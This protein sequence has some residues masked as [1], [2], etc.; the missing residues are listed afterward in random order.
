MTRRLAFAFCLVAGMAFGHTAESAGAAPSDLDPAIVGVLQKDGIRVKDGAKVVMEFWFVSA[1]PGGSASGAPN[2][3]MPELPHGALMGVVRF[4]A[5]YMD[6]RGQSIQPGVYSMRFSFYPENGDHQGA[7]PQRDFLVLSPIANDKDP[8][9]TPAFDALM[10]MSR[11]ASGTPHPLVLSMWKQDAA[12]FKPGV[13][14]EGESDQALQLKV[15]ETPI[16]VIVAGVSN[17]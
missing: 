1:L 17:H 11:K 9:A 14:A 13:A 4:P 7:A 3:T 15:G 8:K 10:E 12:A 5:K 2:V 16:A 6:R